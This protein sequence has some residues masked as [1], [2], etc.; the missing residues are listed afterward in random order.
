M[1]RLRAAVLLVLTIV[2][3]LAA[4]D[5]ASQIPT[6]VTTGEAVVRRAPD[7]A[8]I[9]ASVDTRARNPRDAQRQNAD[10]MTAVQ[11]RLADAAIPKDAIRTTGYSVQQEFDYSNGRRIPREYVAHNGIEIRVDA[12]DR[13]G[14]ILDV[15]VQAG[16]TAAGGV[17]FDIRD[18][19]GAEREALRLAV[20]DARGR[21]DAL[22]AG[23]GRTV[24]RIL[25]IDDSRQ[26]SIVPMPRQE[27]MSKTA[28]A[29]TP[30]E[31]ATIEIHAHIVLTVA[32]K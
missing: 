31:P 24:D 8:F 23:A 2:A 28:D 21:A 6:I 5:S 19:A 17:R 13:T 12:V 10:M 15:V 7:Q 18:R 11:Q 16:A 20:A 3:P 22:A 9:G 32:M 30:I 26:Q 29:A 4:Q 1:H 25:H 14:D 27:M